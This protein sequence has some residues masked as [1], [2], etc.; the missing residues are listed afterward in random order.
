MNR[1]IVERHI[2]VERRKK[3]KVSRPMNSFMLY[4]SAYT[5]RTKALLHLKNHQEV[6]RA[7]GKSW[8]METPY[9]RM[10]YEELADIEKEKHC[11]A[12]PY[13]KFAPKKEVE[14]KKKRVSDDGDYADIDDVEFAPEPLPPHITRS[15]D[16]DVDSNYSNF[17]SRGSTPFDQPIH[18]L[19]TS[20]SILTWQ[21]TLPGGPD[22]GLMG[23]EDQSYLQTSIREGPMGA[24]VEDVFGRAGY[25]DMPCT[26][27]SELTG[28]P[29]ASHYALMQ[30]QTPGPS[31]AD[32]QLDPRLLMHGSESPVGA[33][34][35][36]QPNYQ[37]WHEPQGNN[38]YLPIPSSVPHSPAPYPMTS[39]SFHHP[40][41]QPIMDHGD[42][43]DSS[44]DG[45]D[46]PGGPFEMVDHPTPGY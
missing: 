25:P 9:I 45:L 39:G 13:Y 24:R 46:A 28:L 31:N 17:D 11:L 3:K 5:D 41:M 20:G 23:P 42:S 32:G 43:F 18:G 16:S 1:P 30:P 15:W 40:G 14:P 10:M 19:P 33:S 6:S 38:T 7:S 27:S 34:P 26:S 37:A 4:R 8:G 44:H 35:F 12:H 29:G 36:H 2:E 22:A 21:T